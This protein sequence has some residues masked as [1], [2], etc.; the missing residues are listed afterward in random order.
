[1]NLR[2]LCKLFLFSKNI[3]KKV[4]NFF[5]DASQMFTHKDETKS[6]EEQNLNHMIIPSE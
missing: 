4:K 5:T 1:M 6:N 2:F 3:E